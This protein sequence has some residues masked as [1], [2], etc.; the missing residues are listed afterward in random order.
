[1]IKKTRRVLA[2]GI[3]FLAFIVLAIRIGVA[4]LV[5]QTHYFEDIAT[6]SFLHTVKIQSV[7]TYWKGVH[8]LFALKDVT[9]LGDDGKQILIEMDHLNIGIDFLSSFLHWTFIPGMLEVSGAKISLFQDQ[10]G[11]WKIADLNQNATSTATEFNEW[12]K[13]LA[14]QKQISL[15]DIHIQF[16][17]THQKII[18]ID[19]EKIESFSRIFSTQIEGE[20]SIKQPRLATLHL[21]AILKKTLRFESMEANLYLNAENLDVGPWIKTF[22]LEG[23]TINQGILSTQIWATW[24]NKK[25][26]SVQV[27]FSGKD[28]SLKNKNKIISL[29]LEPIQLVWNRLD[30]EVWQLRGLIE[31]ASINHSIEINEPIVFLYQQAPKQQQ[32]QIKEVSFSLLNSLIPLFSD[33]ENDEITLFKKANLSGFLRNIY[34]QKKEDTWLLDGELENLK[35]DPIDEIPGVVNLSGGFQIRPDMGFFDFDSKNLSMMFPKV[36][37]STVVL[38]RAAGKINWG[39]RPGGFLIQ[40]RDGRIVNVD[41]AAYGQ[42]SLWV[43]EKQK[44]SWISLLGGGVLNSL[45]RRALYLPFTVM[46]TEVV[47]WIDQA[48]MAGKGESSATVVLNGP[49]EQF[50]FDNH[51]GQFTVDATLK[52]VAL[53]IEK[54][55]PTISEITG[56]LIFNNRSMFFKEGAGKIATSTTLSNLQASIPY[57]G[58]ATAAVLNVSG[59]AKTSVEDALMFIHQSPLNALL[60]YRLAAFEGRGPLD[61]KL[62]FSLPLSDSK[63]KVNFNGSLKFLGD[64]LGVTPIFIEKLKGKLRFTELGFSSPF[65]EG[66]LG[67]FPLLIKIGSKN[68]DH[69]SMSYGTVRGKFSSALLNNADS[70]IIFEKYLK[71]ESD[72]IA[73]FNFYHSDDNKNLPLDQFELSSD[74]KGLA[75]HLP[76]PFG[77][78]EQDS[79]YL[80]LKIKWITEGFVLQLTEGE[81]IQGLFSFSGKDKTFDKGVLGINLP[82]VALSSSPGLLIIGNMPGFD[83]QAWRKI[84]DENTPK[85]EN[86]N[87]KNFPSFLRKI[88]LTIGK[89]NIGGKDWEN[90]RV[91]LEEE[92][93]VRV[94]D[95]QNSFLN[96]KFYLT[97]NSDALKI[98]L[99]TL[100]LPE[101]S[102]T[103]TKI[104]PREL[105]A[106]DFDC[107][108]VRIGN[109]DLGHISFLT[110]PSSEGLSIDK[111]SLT[112]GHC[113]LN[114]RGEWQKSKNQE[115]SK[116]IG[117]ISSS[118]LAQTFQSWGMTPG[119]VSHNALGHFS[120]Q[121]TGSPFG[122]NMKTLNGEFDLNIENGAFTDVGESASLKIGLG[123]LLTLLSLQSI[124]QHLQ[125]NFSDLT[126]KGFNFKILKGR[127][128]LNQGQAVT[129]GVFI[130]GPVAKVK[131]SGRI[132]LSTH[133]YDLQL[134]ITPYVT[135]SLPIIATVA[136]G[137]V[138]GAVAWVTDKVLSP[139]VQKLTTYHYHVTGMWDSP[140]INKD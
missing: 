135:S 13:W 36:F 63:Q 32:F 90:T 7:S 42:L 77:K 137:P 99:D 89:M 76:A 103:D 95:L 37:R 45:D 93:N 43:D 129:E 8:P 94:V 26:D 27:S 123:R 91:Q 62:S 118:D 12:L 116:L 6:R 134:D 35:S 1:M 126:D 97:E 72:F 127:F 16:Q 139:V 65:I 20:V 67:G 107:T 14:T 125:L 96:G 136:G 75:I 29:T 57:M 80:S 40:L 5:Q 47:D 128:S 17:T 124:Q 15:T 120:L 11:H 54:D 79:K 51:E 21:V 131:M 59:N 4:H 68:S 61:L 108:S 39:K 133:D 112:S 52:N 41:G 24:K 82:P 50:P 31:E 87:E 18:P 3:V 98:R 111:L 88:D 23:W 100:S 69:W 138:V 28:V 30:N 38:D 56:N 10:L 22:E 34:F 105:P 102:D 114:A 86:K 117:S 121:W 113:A 140:V 101:V 106:L 49:L 92:N 64:T 19:I 110:T 48:V 73:N 55:W 122:L 115:I 109:K 84:I 2:I 53:H 104:S 83:W 58:P 71:G 25:W 33:F 9:I 85:K 81:E 60:K 132:G 44:N 70:N 46:P 119:V 78:A 74:L 130:D 66:E